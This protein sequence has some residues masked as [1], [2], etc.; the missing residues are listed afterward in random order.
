MKDEHTPPDNR[1]ERYSLRGHLGRLRRSG[2]LKQVA[3]VSAA[4]VAI[5]GIAFGRCSSSGITG[6]SEVATATQPS[7]DLLGGGSGSE[8][9]P[10]NNTFKFPVARDVVNACNGQPVHL[11]GEVHVEQYSHAKETGEFHSHEHVIDQLKG[12]SM[13]GTTQ[14]TAS[15]EHLDASRIDFV[16]GKAYMSHYRYDKLI[17]NGPQP[18]FFVRTKSVMKFNAE[19]LLGSPPVPEIDFDVDCKGT[20]RPGEKCLDP[21]PPSGCTPILD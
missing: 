20:C 11:T 15:D 13:D 9:K 21:C 5:G 2:R 17:A 18:D 12:A 8:F 10:I 6:P 19:D 3:L 16:D 7:A 14:Y 1:R 4:V